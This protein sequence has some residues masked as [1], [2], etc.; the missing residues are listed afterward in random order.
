MPLAIKIFFTHAFLFVLF[1][2]VAAV[3]FD[4]ELEHTV[5]DIAVILFLCFFLWPLY[6][7][8]S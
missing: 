8:W 6:F 3:G 2:F 1:L 7:I 5:W 4:M